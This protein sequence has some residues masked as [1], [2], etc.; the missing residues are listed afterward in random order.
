MCTADYV[1]CTVNYDLVGEDCG[2]KEWLLNHNI[3]IPSLTEELQPFP[4]D[5]VEELFSELK[6][7]QHLVFIIKV[8]LLKIPIFNEFLIN[9]IFTE[10]S[11]IINSEQMCP[12]I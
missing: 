3:M 1:E 12:K 7:L 8:T 11:S 9:T 10:T 6:N 2:I 5:A 4:I